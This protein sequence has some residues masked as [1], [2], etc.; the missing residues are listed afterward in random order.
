MNLIMECKD[1]I[2]GYRT[3]QVLYNGAGLARIGPGIVDLFGVLVMYVCDES[4]GI[5]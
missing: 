2:D 3:G 4:V 1:I 5:E